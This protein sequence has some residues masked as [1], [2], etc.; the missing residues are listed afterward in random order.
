MFPLAHPRAAGQHSDGVP[1][2][3]PLPPQLALARLL[4]QLP[5]SGT[6]Q[7]PPQVPAGTKPGPRRPLPR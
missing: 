2:T 4:L 7:V 1:A 3:L 5:Q 6:T